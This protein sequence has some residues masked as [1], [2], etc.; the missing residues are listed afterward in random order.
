MD[1]RTTQ[2][3]IFDIRRFST[4]DGSG[5]RTTV[6]FKGCPLS[7]V[8]CHNPEGISTRSRPL[9]FSNK[10][11]GCRI[12]CELS[13]NGGIVAE[14]DKIRLDITKQEDWNHIIE[15]CPAGAIVW[16]SQRMTVDEVVEQVMKDKAFYKHGGGVTLSGGEPLMQPG[17]ALELLK[18]LKAGNIHTAVETALYVPTETLKAMLPWLDTIYADFKI[19]DPLEHR[20]YTGV[21]NEQI[22][23]NLRYLLESEKRGCVII[24]TPMIP[25]ITTGKDNIAEISRFISGIYEDVSYEILNYN[26][27]AESKYHLIDKTYYF[28]D[29]PKRYS[30]QAMEKFTGIARSNGVHNI[31]LES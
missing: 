7:C 20:K 2:G 29:N 30:R 15:E 28:K 1:G 17:F 16:D 3:T 12:C 27:L 26:P 4:H 14:G 11:I 21:S 8:W 24:R 18:K 23:K 22:K 19:A 31:I 5:I 13:V 9:Y 6:F 10:C 25:G